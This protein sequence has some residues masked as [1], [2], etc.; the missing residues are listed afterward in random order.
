VTSC[1]SN[2]TKLTAILFLSVLHTLFA[3]NW[4]VDFFSNYGTFC[5]PGMTHPKFWVGDSILGLSQCG[6]AVKP[7]PHW[8]FRLSKRMPGYIVFIQATVATPLCPYVL[9]FTTIIPLV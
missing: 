8:A 3:V 4:P 5:V 7:N 9:Q 1:N 2:F 6:T